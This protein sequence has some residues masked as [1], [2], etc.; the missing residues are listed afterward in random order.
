MNWIDTLMIGYYLSE[1]EVGSYN[2]ATKISLV[3]TILLVG[4]NGVIA[5]QISSLY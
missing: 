5:S 2:I 4:V 3:P 1:T